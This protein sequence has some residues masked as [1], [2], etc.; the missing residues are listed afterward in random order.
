MDYSEEY[1]CW[2]MDQEH[3]EQ[4]AENTNEYELLQASGSTYF[5]D[6]NSQN[7]LKAAIIDDDDDDDDGDINFGWSSAGELG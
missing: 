4:L 5:V 1:D 3:Y 2:V 7:A 6:I